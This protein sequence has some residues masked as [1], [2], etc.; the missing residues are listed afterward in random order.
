ME[1][2]SEHDAVNFTGAI[3]TRSLGSEASKNR[4]AVGSCRTA[5]GRRTVAG[6]SDSAGPA[7][8]ALSSLT[9]GAAAAA[10]RRLIVVIIRP[11]SFQ[12]SPAAPT[13]SVRCF[14]N[15]PSAR[16]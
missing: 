7:H 11:A 2:H 12:Y 8:P 5:E 9:T 16:S 14:Q 15:T 1:F 6:T 4:E 3:P 13:N 10:S